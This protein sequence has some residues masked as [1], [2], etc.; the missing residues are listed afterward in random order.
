VRGKADRPCLEVHLLDSGKG[1]SAEELERA[2]EPFFSTKGGGK[3]TGLGLSI[4][5]EIVRGHR[6]EIEIRSVP[7]RGTEAILRLPQ[8]AA[9]SLPDAVPPA[10]AARH[11]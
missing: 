3:G 4:V 2:F 1:M 10:E 6:G 8:A 9:P 11:A 7:G 5:E